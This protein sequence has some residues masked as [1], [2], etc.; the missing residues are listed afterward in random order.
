MRRERARGSQMDGTDSASLLLLSCSNEKLSGG[1]PYG[2]IQG[3]T[4]GSFLSRPM[5]RR[6]FNRRNQMRGMLKE[7]TRRRLHNQDQMA[8]FRDARPRNLDLQ[9]GPDFGREAIGACYRRACERYHGRLSTRLASRASSF[10]SDL[11]VNGGVEIAFLSAL[12]GLVLWDEPIQDY[13]CHFA[14][15]R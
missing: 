8:G 10:W 4:I 1:S 13:D 6:L 3:R 5:R 7:R 11:R 14:D 12:Y 2:E 15:Y 9:E